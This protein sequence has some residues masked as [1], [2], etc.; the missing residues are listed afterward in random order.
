MDFVRVPPVIDDEEL[1]WVPSEEVD[2]VR[3]CVLDSSS[4]EEF[5]L[6]SGGG[7][8]LTGGAGGGAG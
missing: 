7:C 3:E 2:E 4:E 8:F 5:R 6:G 1:S